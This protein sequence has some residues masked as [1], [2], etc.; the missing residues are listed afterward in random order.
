MNEINYVQ[1]LANLLGIGVIFTILAYFI[2]KWING[3]G[4]AIDRKVEREICELNHKHL[5]QIL[6]GMME[7]HKALMDKVIDR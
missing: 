2:K 3:T 5:D 6:A 4:E 7:V 1:V